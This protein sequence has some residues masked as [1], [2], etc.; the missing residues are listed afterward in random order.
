MVGN[1][2]NHD[3]CIDSIFNCE[4]N[5]IYLSSFM[6]SFD[7]SANIVGEWIL[8]RGKQP[9]GKIGSWE[10]LKQINKTLYRDHYGVSLVGKWTVDS[11]Q[12]TV[13]CV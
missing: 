11:G 1:P 6:A 5:C 13:C 8:Y 12:C 2:G 10:V 4:H 3:E 7:I 9:E